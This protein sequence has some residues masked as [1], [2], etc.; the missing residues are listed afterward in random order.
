MLAGHLLSVQG[1]ALYW[2]LWFLW[3][4]STCFRTVSVQ[5]YVCVHAHACQLVSAQ[6]HTCDQESTP[7]GCPLSAHP[8]H[9][10]EA[11]V[12]KLQPT[13]PSWHWGFA[14]QHPDHQKWVLVA[15]LVTYYLSS[16]M[17]EG[18]LY[19]WKHPSQGRWCKR[20]RHSVWGDENTVE[21]DGG[22][23]CTAMGLY[24]MPPNCTLK[25]G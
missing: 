17:W 7:R 10:P 21:V 8:R 24:F 3:L 23:G 2:L 15:A 25:N 12:T 9:P 1:H 14:F 6:I 11:S 16:P 5:V 20:L 13:D 4:T 19:W 18:G 22:Y